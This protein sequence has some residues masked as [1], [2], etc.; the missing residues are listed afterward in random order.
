MTSTDH[1]AEAL[2][3]IAVSANIVRPNDEGHCEADRVLAEAQIHATLAEKGIDHTEHQAVVGELAALR[4]LVARHMYESRGDKELTARLARTAA[5]PPAANIWP[6]NITTKPAPNRPR[7]H[8]LAC[9]CGWQSDPINLLG[10]GQPE[11]RHLAKVH[12]CTNP[13]A[14][15]INRGRAAL[16]R[17]DGAPSEDA[18]A[19]A[20]DD[21]SDAFRTLDLLLATGSPK[22]D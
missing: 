17:M 16:D 21:L 15:T 3:L 20:V 14:S 10:G 12:R 18:Y 2:R 19:D 11:A 5:E 7:L 9:T 6:D 8:C 4:R 13:L 22:T 1:R